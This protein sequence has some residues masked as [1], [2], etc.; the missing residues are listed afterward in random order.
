MTQIRL[1]P[2]ATGSELLRASNTMTWR[3]MEP[4]RRLVAILGFFAA[5]IVMALIAGLVIGTTPS[6][7]VL[8]GLYATL[9]AL[10]ALILIQRL[11]GRR[12]AADYGSS[13]WRC[14]DVVLVLDKDGLLAEERRLRWS[15]V[16]GTQRIG[17][18][19]LLMFTGAD[20]MM[21]CD[22]DLPPG[23]TPAELQRQI[24]EWRRGQA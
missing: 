22:R 2:S 17:E 6:Q 15:D 23:M 5:G 24:A 10:L 18:S 12:L 21:I 9:G 20:G 11:N 1:T 4:W 19:T 16:R 7:S 13:D 8:I 3:F 14:R